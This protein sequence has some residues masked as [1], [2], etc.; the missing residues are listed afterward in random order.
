MIYPIHNI[1][2]IAAQISNY[3][4]KRKKPE[5]IDESFLTIRALLFAHRHC[6]VW[7]FLVRITL[8]FLFFICDKEYMYLFYTHI[9][10]AHRVGLL[11]SING[12]CV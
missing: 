4:K 10:M 3:K 11:I 2:Y 1:Q 9:L 12:S 7:I 8:A 6:F 5:V